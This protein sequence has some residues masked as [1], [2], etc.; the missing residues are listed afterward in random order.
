MKIKRVLGTILASVTLAGCSG[1]NNADSLL[2]NACTKFMQEIDISDL[3]VSGDTVNLFANAAEADPKYK[4]ISIAADQLLAA[5]VQKKSGAN[6]AVVNNSIA[7][8]GTVV[9]RSCVENQK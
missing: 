7:A 2:A 4:D 9:I 3:N 6:N 5:I 8:N 1:S